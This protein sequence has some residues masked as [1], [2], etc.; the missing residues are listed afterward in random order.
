MSF[1][2][3]LLELGTISVTAINVVEDQVKLEGETNK[4]SSEEEQRDRT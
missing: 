2:D 1:K 3:R 4:K